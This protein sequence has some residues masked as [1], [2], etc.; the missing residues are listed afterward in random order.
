LKAA[1]NSARNRVRERC[2]S[3]S[4]NVFNQKMATRNQG[5]YRKPD[6]LGLTLDYGLNDLLKPADMFYRGRSRFV[7]L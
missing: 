5:N 6:G 3:Y 1:V 4:G 7:T 2:L